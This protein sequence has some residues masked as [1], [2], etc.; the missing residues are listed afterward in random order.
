MNVPWIKTLDTV[1]S[2]KKEK[3]KM[4]ELKR[5]PIEGSVFKNLTCNNKK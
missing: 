2:N 3:Y 4:N 5:I 1:T